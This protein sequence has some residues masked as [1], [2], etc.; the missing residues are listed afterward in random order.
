[1]GAHF[2]ASIFKWLKE[3]L[4]WG[5]NIS[6]D[7]NFISGKMWCW[8]FFNSHSRTKYFLARV[9]VPHL[10]CFHHWTF[11]LLFMTLAFIGKLFSR[12]FYTHIQSHHREKREELHFH[13]STLSITIIVSYRVDEN[14][15]E[16]AKKKF[17]Q[18]LMRK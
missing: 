7:F 8:E 1:M 16:V 10:A 17:I 4:L 13:Y 9:L 2:L 15:E 18:W 14:V 5:Q 12:F 11:E 3:S 6:F